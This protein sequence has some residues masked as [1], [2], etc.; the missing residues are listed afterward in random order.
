LKAYPHVYQTS[1]QGAASG[2]V[3]VSAAEVSDIETAPPPE[4]DGPGG[5]WSPETLL[6]ASV[7]DCFI[8]T[9]RGVARAGRFEWERLDAQVEGTLERI[10]G[11]AQFTRYITRAVLTVKPGA[12]HQ[13][14]MELMGRA[15][16]ACLI[17]NSLRGERLLEA[18]V[19]VS[20]A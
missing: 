18:T 5:T 14:A 7:A 10:A 20:S 13:K 3:R 6:I 8:L 9:F 2:T 1:A 16:H 12:D 19:S 15:E 17:A 11:V 4:F